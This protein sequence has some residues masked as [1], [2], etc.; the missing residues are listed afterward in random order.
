MST[1]I[2]DVIYEPPG[3]K[4]RK[5]ITIFTMVSL[6]AIA[7][8]IAVIIRQFYITGQLDAK[9]WLFFTK[10]STWKF[11]GKGLAGTLKAAI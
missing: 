10:Y 2:R 8:L 4:T 3:P 7:A 11:L 1:S 9:Y 6:A 5:W